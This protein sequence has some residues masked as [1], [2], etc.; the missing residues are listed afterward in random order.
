MAATAGRARAWSASIDRSGW[1]A[2]AASWMGWMFDG[3]EIYALVLVMGVAA[4]ELLPP[5]ALPHVSVYMGGL[6]AVTLLG[7]AAGGVIAGVLADYI[8]R[9]RM[10]MISI[11]W[12]AVF[13]G[14]TALSWDYW[15]L[16]IFRFFTGL[17][18]G[19][20][21]GPGTAIVAEFW[22]PASRGRAG[23]AL[24][25]ANGVGLFLASGMWLLLNP[26]G[27]SSW[28]YMFVIG[29]LP[30]FLLLYVRRAVHDPALWVAANNRRREARKRLEMGVV[31]LQDRELAQFTITSVL[32]DPELRR[33]VGLLRLMSRSTVVGGWSVSTWIPQYAAQLAI[34]G[35]HQSQLSASLVTIMFSAG[36][37]AGYLVLGWLADIFG[38]K[39]ATWLYYLGALGVSLC[40]F[41]LVQ[42]TR[43]LLVMAAATG[44]FTNGQ[45]AWMTIYLP[46]LFPTRVRGSA[47]SLVF[48][49]SRSIAAFGPLL[50]GW[51]ISSFGIGTSAAMMSLI[52]VVGLVVTPFAGPET[53]GKPLPA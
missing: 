9:K 40:F 33:R 26:F 5:D 1:R 48:D 18:L 53:K 46:E 38:R 10:L 16:L 45:F 2:L 24:H 32:S 50:A 36:A 30:A 37:I 47:I 23:G 20:E 34:N 3:Y 13:A 7:W 6:L 44:F 27:S 43:A 41:L 52:Y 4:R 25:A 8:G 31:S 15:S 49:S 29:I 28:R 17:G 22:P 39:P 35:G 21:W 51:L 19:A 42:D 12:Y 14:L 11:L